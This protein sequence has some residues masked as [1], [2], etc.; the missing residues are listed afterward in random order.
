MDGQ[1][2][3]RGLVRR[4][5]VEVAPDDGGQTIEGVERYGQPQRL[6]QSRRVPADQG[7]GQGGGHVE[8]DAHDTD[9]LTARA[10]NRCHD[11]DFTTGLEG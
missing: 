2:L 9:P 4:P 7:P 10:R 3:Q 6:P 11:G 1:V 5:R 8:V